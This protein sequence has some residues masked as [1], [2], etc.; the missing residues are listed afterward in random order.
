[1]PK[2]PKKL[3]NLPL[4]L[5]N[6]TKPQLSS[7]NAEIFSLKIYKPQLVKKFSSKRRKSTPELD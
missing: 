5:P 7:P 6:I 4:L 1:M 2:E 3:K